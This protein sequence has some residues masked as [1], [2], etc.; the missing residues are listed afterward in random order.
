MVIDWVSFQFG[1]NDFD[2][3]FWMDTNILEY[4]QAE[5]G[6]NRHLNANGFLY[7]FYSSYNEYEIKLDFEIKY[8]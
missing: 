6:R 3:R 4:N 5:L 1:S 2:V 7:R 8:F